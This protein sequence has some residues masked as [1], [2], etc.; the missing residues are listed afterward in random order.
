MPQRAPTARPLGPDADGQWVRQWTSPEWTRKVDGWVGRQLADQ[1]RRVAGEPVTYRARFWSVVRCFPTD[2]GLVW[3]KE[4]NPGQHFEASLTEAL[5]RLVPDLVAVPIAIDRP[6]G[7]LLTDD[8]G[9]T[10]DHDDVL[11]HGIRHAV[12]RA[13]ARLQCSL[14][15]RLSVDDHPGLATLLPD[16]AGDFVR[17]I[18]H[19]WVTLPP[20]HPLHAD[21]GLVDRAEKAAA[22]LDRRAAHLGHGGVPL[23]LDVNDVYPAN[24]CVD[25]ST[26]TLQLRFFDF[27]NAIWGH[28]FVTLHGFLGSVEEWNQAPLSPTDRESLYNSYLEIWRDHLQTD[29]RSLRTQLEATRDLVHVHKLIAWLRLVPHADSLELRTRAE[30]PL[31][32]FTEIANLAG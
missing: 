26:G 21:V 28:P 6:R 9:A 27:G 11:N 30:I 16:T 8:H 15:G 12:V 23:D 13:L 18:A 22:L 3:F 32:W 24:I 20:D 17:A 31:K 2:E 19:E 5:A 4:T 14:L 29:H 10:L 7:R 1:G 25:R